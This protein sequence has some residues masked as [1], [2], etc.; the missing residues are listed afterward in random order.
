MFERYTEKARR[1]IFFSRYEASQYG[2]PCIETEHLL[3]GLLREDKRI[4]LRL[5]FENAEAVRREIDARSPKR[6]TFPT[7]V[8]LPLTNESKR[9]LA[10]A[11]EEAERLENPHIGTEHLLLG[12]LRVEDCFGAEILRNN[13]VNLRAL[14]EQLG[15]AP[16]LRPAFR[17]PQYRPPPQARVELHG[18]MWD[19]DYLHDR[20]KACREYSWH[21]EKRT[22][23]P[24]DI[25][26][27]RGSGTVSFDTKLG[28][29]TKLFQLVKAGWKKDHCYVCRW[30]LFESKDDPTHGTGYTN[31][32]EW[33]CTECYEKFWGNPN[34][35]ASN[36]PD[37]T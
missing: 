33:L 37:I 21:W 3:L 30:E 29:K 4:F 16:P 13:G 32:R 12:L 20:V 10:Y 11:A 28:K 25:A 18:A 9:V 26:I 36:Y 6:P 17:S 15:A 34:F 8:D 27:H 31:G 24:R 2:S 14:R 5:K 7:S 22:Y 35:F 1:V 19:G 23:T